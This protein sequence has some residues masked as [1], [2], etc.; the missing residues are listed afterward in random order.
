MNVQMAS[1][2]SPSLPAYV[3]PGAGVSITWSPSSPSQG[4]NAG[5]QGQA[6]GALQVGYEFN[7]GDAFWEIGAGWP[8]GASLTGYYVF[9]SISE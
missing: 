3:T 2:R 5:I 8:P 1:A 4:W 7:G 9:E 6:I